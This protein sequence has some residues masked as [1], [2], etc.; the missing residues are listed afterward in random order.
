MSD[1]ARDIEIEGFKIEAYTT[2]GCFYR[3]LGSIVL[4][5]IQDDAKL[6]GS[7][8]QALKISDFIYVRIVP[9]EAGG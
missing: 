3:R 9:A 8:K 4:G 5:E 1:G 2:S 6:L 7:V